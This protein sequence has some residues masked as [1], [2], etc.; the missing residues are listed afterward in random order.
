MSALEQFLLSGE[1]EDQQQ[2]I[3]VRLS[4]R[5]KFP[6]KVRALTQEENKTIRKSCQRTT[7]DKKTRQKV[8]ETDTDLYTDRLMVASTV[9]PNFKSAELQER[10][11]VRDGKAES[12]L[13]VMLRSGEYTA[14]MDAV[15]EVNGYKDDVNDLI[16]E[17]KN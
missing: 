12:L 8:T 1:F 6:F 9:D 17:A 10:F 2:E 11:G 16:E 14:L 5:F 15:M 4:D 13:G 3:E 7:I